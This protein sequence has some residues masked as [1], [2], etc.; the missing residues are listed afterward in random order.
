MS[1]FI[2]KD[3]NWGKSKDAKT[4]ALPIPEKKG[5]CDCIPFELQASKNSID[6]IL[7]SSSDYDKD[8]RYVIEWKSA[9][10]NLEN[11]TTHTEV[12]LNNFTNN[13]FKTTIN[14]LANTTNY[15]IRILN[16]CRNYDNTEKLL[17]TDLCNSKLIKTGVS[18]CPTIQNRLGDL[19]RYNINYQSTEYYINELFIT[20][21]NWFGIKQIELSLNN[22]KIIL[23][24]PANQNGEYRTNLLKSYPLT[25][26]ESFII[27]LKSICGDNLV[28]DTTQFTSPIIQE[29]EFNLE[30]PQCIEYTI[31]SFDILNINETIAKFNLI[32]KPGLLFQSYKYKYKINIIDKDGNLL[33]PNQNYTN[34]SE[35]NKKIEISLIN[36]DIKKINGFNITFN[37]ECLFSN[38]TITETTSNIDYS[39]NIKDKICPNI[40]ISDLIYEKLDNGL[41]DII[42]KWSFDNE[43]VISNIDYFKLIYS[44]NGERGGIEVSPLL[45]EYKFSNQIKNLEFKTYIEWKCNDT[46]I[47]NTKEFTL[48]TPNIDI[49]PDIKLEIIGIP[50]DLTKISPNPISV[51]IG[52]KN[53]L[54]GN[55]NQLKLKIL[56]E[57]KLLVDK[58]YFNN[59]LI[60]EIKFE[61]NDFNP[62]TS[63]TITAQGG[64]YNGINDTLCN[65]TTL[66]Y[67]PLFEYTCKSVLN[68]LNIE[69][70]GSDRIKLTWDANISN[71]DIFYGFK[72]NITPQPLNNDTYPFYI[73]DKNVRFIDIGGLDKR[74]DYGISLTTTCAE[75][76]KGIP[77]IINGDYIPGNDGSNILSSFKGSTISKICDGIKDFNLISEGN[78]IIVTANIQNNYKKILVQWKKDT[79]TLWNEKIISSFPYTISNLNHT[80]TY[81]VRVVTTCSDNTEFISNP[82]SIIT[83]FSNCSNTT[84]GIVIKNITQNSMEINWNPI[85]NIPPNDTI[86]Y[87][88]KWKKTTEIN[89]NNEQFIN[90]FNSNRYLITGLDENFNYDIQMITKCRLS[91]SLPNNKNQSTSTCNAPLLNFNAGFNNINLNWLNESN[92]TGYEI[93]WREN[94]TNTYNQNTVNGNE[95]NIVN[96]IPNKEYEIRI[97]SK[98]SNGEFSEWSDTI[99]IK[100]QDCNVTNQ[101]L[102]I[103]EK[104]FD[105]V[106]LSWSGIN[107]Y[108]DNNY[109]KLRWRISGTSTWNDINNIKSNTYKLN[110][111]ISATKYEF[112]LIRICSGIES[113]SSDIINDTTNLCEKISGLSNTIENNNISLSWNIINNGNYSVLWYIDN[114]LNGRV[115]NLTQ[116]TY[117]ISNIQY[118]KNYSVEVINVCSGVNSEASIINISLSCNNNPNLKIDSTTSNG[119]LLNWNTEIMNYDQSNYYKLLWKKRIDNTFN[120]IAIRSNPPYLFTSFENG[121]EYE[122]NLIRVCNGIDSSLTNSVTTII[123]NCTAINGITIKEIQNDGILFNLGNNNNLKLVYYEKGSNNKITLDITANGEYK[124]TGLVLGKEYVFDFY[125]NCG[126]GFIS[127]LPQSITA[128]FGLCNSP[129]NFI[130]ILQSGNQVTVTS[131]KLDPYP[132]Y[133]FEVYDKLTGNLVDKKEGKNR[134][135]TLT[136]PELNNNY[137][138]RVYIKCDNGLISS[139]KIQDKFIWDCFAPTIEIQASRNANTIEYFVN[140][141]QNP[142]NQPVS[143]VRSLWLIRKKDGSRQDLIIDNRDLINGNNVGLPYTIP[144][145]NLYNKDDLYTFHL[146]TICTTSNKE[147]EIT[148]EFNFFTCFNPLINQS[149]NLT[150]NNGNILITISENLPDYYY[151]L[152]YSLK[153]SYNV[154]YRQNNN[155][156]NNS[157]N[158]RTSNEN[159]PDNINGW[160]LFSNIT[161]AQNTNQQININN[162]QRNTY[163]EILILPDCYG[164]TDVVEY[165]WIYLTAKSGN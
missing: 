119:I 26:N 62:F 112:S 127:T 4:L 124:L 30:Q 21:D 78:E 110:N 121:F 20:S 113:L 154:Y 136:V 37:T 64:L 88:I 48:D 19:I 16:Y 54:S 39:F 158:I 69:D 22:N 133:I 5:K 139:P 38:H 82:N 109:F 155:I 108:D 60:N 57:N 49:C 149:Q 59:D 17:S 90:G 85:S 97:R 61:W 138:F 159:Q 144:N 98:C 120:Q 46:I 140:I 104:G 122:F 58:D 131:E 36:Y 81:L 130:S 145:N 146:K 165:Q 52:I 134:Q 14:N 53:V 89:F 25:Y 41:F 93:Q 135:Q 3:L 32:T 10:N 118:N 8:N 156:N 50:E 99:K 83:S 80:T 47:Q 164:R 116:N 71:D 132:Y 100:T 153:P 94:G 66:T 33:N 162:I 51:T 96:L 137:E 68:N 107:T 7:T 101:N 45:K 142:N 95:F 105:Y 157:I 35:N 13:N 31:Q 91:E 72:L 117:V 77:T 106:I 2:Y 123:P 75:I 76:I 125:N 24:I 55:I 27:V 84:S 87:I 74:L 34:L 28:G 115:D 152:N 147:V 141:T 150:G 161:L 148:K 111:L 102:K 12:Q 11:W 92:S 70:I 42:I 18:N 143:E 86:G 56:S 128:V 43:D 63:Y 67:N 129:G 103:S 23:D 163:Y 65:I 29:P 6:I 73:R 44:K 1:N 151:T 126:N 79:D 15:E 160:T 114:I 40:N 9:E